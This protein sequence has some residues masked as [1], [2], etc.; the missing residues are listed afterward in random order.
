MV[1]LKMVNLLLAVIK[2]KTE[3]EVIIMITNIIIPVLI[4]IL[5]VAATTYIVKLRKKGKKLEQ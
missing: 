3:G 4:L 2:I 5:I 1:K